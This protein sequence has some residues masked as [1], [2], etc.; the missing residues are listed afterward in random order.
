M[1]SI[2][3]NSV[4]Q[5]RQSS[6]GKDMAKAGG[7]HTR[8]MA[9]RYSDGQDYEHFPDSDDSL[10]GEIVGRERRRNVTFSLRNNE[11]YPEHM[12]HHRIRCQCSAIRVNEELR[13][14][15]LGT[16]FLLE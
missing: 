12:S 3:R 14:L 15:H 2:G 10:A 16:K 4:Q 11:Q 8:R 7:S 9:S 1:R 6:S 13:E 5:S